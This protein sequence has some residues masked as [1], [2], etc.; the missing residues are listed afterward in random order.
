MLPIAHLSA[1]LLSLSVYDKI[2]KAKNETSFPYFWFIVIGFAGIFPDLLKPHLFVADRISFSHS[3]FFPIFFLGLYLIF[4]SLNIKYRSLVF[5]FFAGAMIH[6]C[7]DMVTGVV[8][9]FYPLS[10]FAINKTVLFP[11]NIIRV[12]GRWYAN[13]SQHAIWYLFD[14]FFFGLY[15]F[16]DKTNL[17]E[18]NLRKL[19]KKNNA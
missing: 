4:K 3:L 9:I 2:K 10:D 15:V 8:F 12:Q 14:A 17:L 11:A 13:L 5:L 1:S 16:V 19:L 6:L 7:L 18:R